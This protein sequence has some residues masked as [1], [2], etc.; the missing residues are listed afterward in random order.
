MG[1][2]AGIMV[3][4]PPLIIPEVGRGEERTIINTIEA[5]R[6]A[7]AF[8][9]YSAPD[10]VVVISP[11]STL[12]GDYFHISP[13]ERASGSFARFG[14][15]TVSLSVDYDEEFVRELE[16]AAANTGLAAGR[17]GGRNRELDH[18]T[19]VP[20]HFLAEACG[21]IKAK[22]VRAALSALSLAEHY[23][24][25]MLI[26]ETSERL[27]RRT[28][29]IA[30]GDLSHRL[31]EDGPYG[32]N[33]SGPLYDERI[34]AVMGNG[35]FGELFNFSE[36]FCDSAGECGHRAFVIMAGCFDGTEVE[37][38]RLSY[39]GPFG[40]GYGV[41][42]FHAAGPDEKR[43]LLAEFE[44]KERTELAALKEKEDA[45]VRLARAAVEAY[46]TGGE[47]IA[48]PAEL[49]E[50]MLSRRAGAFVS[51]KKEGRLRGCIGTIAPTATSVA[52]EIINN[53][54]S[55]ATADPRFDPVEKEEL[56]KLVY[57][58]DIL[59]ETEKI[60]SAAKLDVKRYGVIVTKGGR[61]GLLLPNLEGVDS[62][63]EQISIAKKKAGI[64]ANDKVQLERFEVV[65]HH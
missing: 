49:P 4:H 27:G 21:G 33:P 36:G 28:A 64:G 19:L 51:L 53:A 7:A 60:D 55:A 17:L 14:A 10:T 40:V 62:V 45:Y 34:M 42:T 6:E 52:S 8:V 58:V 56:A 11:H 16:A 65:R 32:F 47:K 20:L 50:E 57:S 30:S 43:R 13:G 29:V 39:E 59:G 15:P 12:Y 24:L 61:R 9:A 26:K 63:E 37:A 31:K 22:V 35:D 46:V 38:K 5:Y 48:V 25:G 41:C 18:A 3:P 2:T 23:R 44:K 1:I 54:V